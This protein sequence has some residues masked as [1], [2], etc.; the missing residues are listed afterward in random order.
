MNPSYFMLFFLVAVFLAIP[1][2]LTFSLHWSTMSQQSTGAPRAVEVALLQTQMER[3]IILIMGRVRLRTRV[4]VR[5]SRAKMSQDTLG[6]LANR[7]SVIPS[8]VTDSVYSKSVGHVQ[9]VSSRMY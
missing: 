7:Y 8:V 9:Y 1:L 4:S 5:T 2:D 3:F 6:A